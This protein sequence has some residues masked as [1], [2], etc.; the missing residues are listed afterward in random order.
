MQPRD[1]RKFG[2]CELALICGVAGSSVGRSITCG[3]AP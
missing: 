3:L 1:E 2:F